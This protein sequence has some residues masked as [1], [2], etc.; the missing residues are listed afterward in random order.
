MKSNLK[1][2]PDNEVMERYSLGHLSGPELESVE[3]HLF[4]CELCQDELILV[5]FYIADLKAG[6]RAVRLQPEPER[7]HWLDWLFTAP[8][9]AMAGGFAVFLLAFVLPLTH[10]P[11]MVGA[12]VVVQLETYRGAE[13]AGTTQAEARRPLHLTWDVPAS[14][15]GPYRVEI[16]DRNGSRVWTGAASGDSKGLFIDVTNSLSAGMYW[17]RLSNAGTMP[18][19]E[20]RLQLK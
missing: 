19:R 10:K 1:I 6:C 3:E 20:Y 14:S 13:R 16:V 2:H 4:V 5:D 8:R 11:A 18:L 17:V 7:V 12:P 9:L 15:S